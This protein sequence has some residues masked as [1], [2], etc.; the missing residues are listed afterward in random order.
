MRGSVR[1]C[2]IIF[3]FL[4]FHLCIVG[5][6]SM[7]IY[8]YIYISPICK[9]VFEDNKLMILLFSLFSRYGKDGKDHQ[10][11]VQRHVFI[12]QSSIRVIS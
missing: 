8:I 7:Y 11:K 10:V 4:L 9:I 5:P 6:T 3:L 1:Y 12:R 2:I